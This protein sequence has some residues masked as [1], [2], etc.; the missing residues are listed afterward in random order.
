MA[1]LFSELGVRAEK[2]GWA[3]EAQVRAIAGVLVL[4]G[5]GLAA[6]VDM[7]W[8]WLTAFVGAN[9]LQSSL[10]G[11]CMMSNILALIERRR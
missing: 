1:T 8:L 4:A 10:T 11:W 6:F 7:R 2:R 5:A 3:V 9:L